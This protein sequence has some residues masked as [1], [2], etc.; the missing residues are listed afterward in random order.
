[1]KREKI[2]DINKIEELYKN[3]K[4][5]R[6]TFWRA[7]KRG[8][9]IINYHSKQK[10]SDYELSEDEKFQLYAYCRASAVNFVTAHMKRIMEYNEMTSLIE[11]IAHDIY[12]YILEKQ[13]VNLKQA[14]SCVKYALLNL[15]QKPMWYGKYLDFPIRRAEAQDKFKELEELVLN[16]SEIAS[17]L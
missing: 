7:K 17:M 12:I 14:F 3:R 16:S 10:L 8:Y 1:M 11:D 2:T 6:S 13:P 15:R 9:I 4:I 5:S